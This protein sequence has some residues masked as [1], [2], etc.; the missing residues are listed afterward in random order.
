MGK[1]ASSNQCFTVLKAETALSANK[2]W[3][4]EEHNKLL[5]ELGVAKP[6]NI[7]IISTVQQEVFNSTLLRVDPKLK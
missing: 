5:V 7:S 6:L 3:G 4:E 2:G 1:H